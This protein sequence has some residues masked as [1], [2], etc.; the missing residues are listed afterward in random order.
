[1]DIGGRQPLSPL[2]ATFLHGQDEPDLTVV[3]WYRLRKRDSKLR[4]FER[5]G[6]P[7]NGGLDNVME[8][9][10]VT[11]TGLT[12]VHLFNLLP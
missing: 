6:F 5:S 3:C 1:M 7:G 9:F 8:R 2:Q 11:S 4:P 10:S 12:L